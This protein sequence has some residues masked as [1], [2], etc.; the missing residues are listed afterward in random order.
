MQIFSFLVGFFI[1][2]ALGIVVFQVME[3]LRLRKYGQHS[4]YSADGN[5]N[6][7]QSVKTTRKSGRK[8]QPV[9]HAAQ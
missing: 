4:S 1:L 7:R 6:F 8:R 2:V 5:E 3:L 9:Y